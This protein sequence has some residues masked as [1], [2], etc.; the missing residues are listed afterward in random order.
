MF[1][2]EKDGSKL[3][4]Y[5]DL[6][7]RRTW[8]KYSMCRDFVK[9]LLTVSRSHIKTLLIQLFYNIQF[10]TRTIYIFL[11]KRYQVIPQIPRKNCSRNIY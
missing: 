4:S 8:H 5:K 3:K 7:Q 9:Y 2:V 11:D 6:Q 1:C 10:R